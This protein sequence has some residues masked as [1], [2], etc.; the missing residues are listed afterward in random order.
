VTKGGGNTVSGG[1]AFA[2]GLKGDMLMMYFEWPLYV[3]TS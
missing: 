2:C 3:S 1:C